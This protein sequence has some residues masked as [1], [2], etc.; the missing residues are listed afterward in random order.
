MSVQLLLELASLAPHEAC[1]GAVKDLCKCLKLL[2]IDVKG[3][4]QRDSVAALRFLGTQV[5][6][7]CTNPP[8]YTVYS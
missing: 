4:E 6:E 2:D 1:A 5:M 3:E 8:V 7:V